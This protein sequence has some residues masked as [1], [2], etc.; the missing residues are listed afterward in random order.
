[1]NLVWLNTNYF[2]NSFKN[3]SSVS[4]GIPSSCAFLSFVPAA[5]PAT[6]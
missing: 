5:S 1:M 2:P 6:T 4:T 3:S